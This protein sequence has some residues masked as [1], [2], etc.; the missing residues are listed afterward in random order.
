MLK[1]LY[2]LFCVN[3]LDNDNKNSASSLL[4]VCLISLVFYV[5]YHLEIPGISLSSNIHQQPISAQWAH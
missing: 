3:M 4:C 1:F 2:F 5:L